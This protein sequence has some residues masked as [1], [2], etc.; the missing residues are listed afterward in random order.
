MTTTDDL[1]YGPIKTKPKRTWEIVD[2]ELTDEF[3]NTFPIKDVRCLVCG[4]EE[5]DDDECPEGKDGEGCGMYDF[6]E[7]EVGSDLEFG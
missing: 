2:K 1:I 5:W 4:M 6:L 3:G 7:S